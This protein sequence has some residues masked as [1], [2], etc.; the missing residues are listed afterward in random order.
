MFSEETDFALESQS[1][2]FSLSN[3]SKFSMLSK[4]WL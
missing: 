3:D 2:N 1:L 4:P